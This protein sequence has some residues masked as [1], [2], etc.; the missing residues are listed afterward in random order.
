MENI[1][2]INKPRGITPLDSILSLKKSR[3]ELSSKTIS[4]AGRLD[5][6][7]EGLLVLLVGEENKKRKQ[8]EGLPKTYEF[9]LLLGITTDTY[10]IL[11]KITSVRLPA[12]TSEKTLLSTLPSFVHT[13]S[14]PYPPYSSKPVN[15]KPLYYW[16]RAGK[17]TE[18]TIPEKIVTITSLTP[19]S[20]I[21]ID[22]SS[23]LSSITADISQVKGD[24][25]QEEILSSWRECATTLPSSLPLLTFR[26]TCTSGVYI[27]SLCQEMGKS[28]GCGALAY[29]IRRTQV[30]EF[31]LQDA[32]T[33]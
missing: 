10:D 21:S 6:M 9:T 12:V 15:G 20:P 24:F 17:L 3:P 33:L 26:I 11:G 14:Q 27:R 22:S 4:F 1:I 8:Y 25:R 32:L 29:R 19:L 2:L 18:I 16:A 7:A 23:L 30:G 5:P 13:F 28:L 31:L